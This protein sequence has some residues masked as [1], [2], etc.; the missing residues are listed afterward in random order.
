MS[1]EFPYWNSWHPNP[2]PP[3]YAIHDTETRRPSSKYLQ[4]RGGWGCSAHIWDLLEDLFTWHHEMLFPKPEESPQ[5]SNGFRFYAFLRNCVTDYFN[6]RACLG[7]WQL[8]SSLFS[9]AHPPPH[10]LSQL[11][12]LIWFLSCLNILFTLTY[13][14]KKHTQRKKVMGQLYFRFVMHKQ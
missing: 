2:P 3:K 13:V 6:H 8:L 1:A 11:C 7:L 14:K 12:L 4:G 10:S 9:H 5:E